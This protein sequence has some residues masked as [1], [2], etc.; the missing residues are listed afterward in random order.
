MFNII[1][2]I[3]SESLMCTAYSVG[4]FYNRK[5]AEKNDNLNIIM[6]SVCSESGT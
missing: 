5:S 6:I 3:S 1:N 2:N 4:L